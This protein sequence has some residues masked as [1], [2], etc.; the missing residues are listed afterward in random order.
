VKAVIEEGTIMRLKMFM[1]RA[2]NFRKQ[3][4][5]LHHSNAILF[6][7]LSITG[8]LLFS[9]L[10]RILFPS[11]RIVVKDIHIW[12]G[13]LSCLPLLFYLL[14]LSK[15][16]KTLR[17]RKT[18][19]INL[20]LVLTIV[21]ILI[22]SGFLL[23]FQ[24]SMPPI[25]GTWALTIHSLAT[26]VGLPYVI[27]H[28]I[29]RSVW[30][31]DIEKR[32]IR[33][34]IQEAPLL[35]EDGNPI[36]KRR[37]FLRMLSGSVITVLF[38]PVIGRWLQLPSLF[39]GEGP[40]GSEAVNSFIPTPQ[41]GPSSLPPIGGGKKGEFRYYTV[42]EIPKLNNENWSFTIDGLVDRKIT[43]RWEEFLQL[44]RVVQVSDF[45][46]VTGWSVYSGT[47]EGI[48][49]KD[50]LQKAGV[51]R[52]ATHVKLYSAD[53]VYTDGLSLDQAMLD[54]VMV[55][56]LFD[57]MPITAKNGGPVRL[58]VPKMYAY[59]AVKWLNRLELVDYEH[60]GYWPMS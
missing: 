7:A 14:Q 35:V 36:Y 20:G 38:L 8:I 37:T 60:I 45:H 39:V 55:A 23:T 46:C 24:R 21:I 50:F 11:F 58:I 57:G 31:R 10:F 5:I 15:H 47:W 54:D 53:G 17:H 28:S 12:L 33:K 16:V 42:T 25:V 40:D 6:F 56:V 19:Q 30:F 3:L 22:I 59:K 32:F 2:M 1:D 18:N 49:L 34:E 29:T 41:P 9:S 43:Y 52:E 13:V 27:Y 26:W 48:P 51:K 44:K 4:K